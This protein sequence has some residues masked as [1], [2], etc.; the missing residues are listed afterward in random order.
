MNKNIFSKHLV[1]PVFLALFFTLSASVSAQ[2]DDA[3]T[4]FRNFKDV[5]AMSIKVP[6]VV[7]VSFDEGEYLGRQTFAVY[8]NNADAFV[9]SFVIE[10]KTFSSQTT[11][12]CRIQL[13]FVQEVE[14]TV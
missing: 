14:R 12:H 7:E 5:P 2:S 6:T 10:N 9:P 8:D 1:L 4:A 11:W 13:K 3:V